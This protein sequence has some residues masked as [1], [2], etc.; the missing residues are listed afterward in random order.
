[1]HEPIVTGILTVAIPT[2]DPDAALH[3][4]TDVLGL[5]LE[6]DLPASATAPRWITLTAGGP[7]T[8]S[9]W[10]PPT[11]A[12]SAPRPTGIRFLTEDAEAARER[13]AAAGA[14][15]GDLLRWPG[16]P[17]MFDASDLDG[18]GFVVMEATP[19]Q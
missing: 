2:T 7:V 15:V 17:A 13:V 16:V 14:T 19:W 1:M 4:Y 6:R 11:G 9:L 12:D 3:F 8:V 18:N 5:T 10:Q